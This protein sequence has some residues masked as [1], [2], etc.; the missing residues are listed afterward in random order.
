MNLNDSLKLLRDYADHGD[1]GAF[2]QLVGQYLDLVYS[3]AIRRVGG[4]AG[5]AQDVTQTVFT[6]LARKAPSLRNVEM[7]GGWL[8]RHTGFVASNL[9]RSEQRRQ[10]REQE[11]AQM[12]AISDSPDNLWQ[13]L[14]PML[15]ETIESLDPS[16]R[17]AVLLRFF[18]RRDFR[19]I[20]NTLNITDDAAQKRVS[21]AVEKLREL[22]TAR[23][24]TL[25][26]ILLSSL[27][28]GRVV[29]AAPTGLAGNVARIALSGTAAGGLGLALLRLTKAHAFKMALGGAAM[30]AV[31]WFFASHRSASAHETTHS[32]ASVT[33]VAAEVNPLASSASSLT[34]STSLATNTNVTGRILLLNVVA[35]DSG[36]PV[37][38]V[39][40]D[41]W[42]WI[43]GNVKH[44]K[45]LLTTRMGASKV[46]VPDDTTELILVSERDGFADTL[47]E[48]HPDHG[49]Q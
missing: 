27:L 43:N 35:A 4:D 7:L 44:K 26:V 5:L 37:P 36:K 19:S 42:L 22:L 25:S 17:Q 13:Q 21:R 16:D 41:Y 46:P 20:G 45:P 1:E 28:A 10:V 15:D 33:L 3:T 49:E 47:L 34:S 48:W 9:V 39:E 30:V 31:L 40:L 29:M 6:D 32:T 12:N 2:R 8:H 14:A 24:V 18:E 23:D 38:D 11:A